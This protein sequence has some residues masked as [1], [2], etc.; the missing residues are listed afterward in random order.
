MRGRP[1]GRL[2]YP[3]GV[4]AGRGDSVDWAHVTD[5]H[6]LCGWY[7][8]RGQVRHRLLGRRP[9]RLARTG[10]EVG[11]AASVRERR[12]RESGDDQADRRWSVRLPSR[13]QA[14]AVAQ[15]LG[16]WHAGDS[17]DHRQ[18]VLSSLNEQVR[19]N[20]I[21]SITCFRTKIFEYVISVLLT[22]R[23]DLFDKA[24]YIRDRLTEI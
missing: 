14:G 19:D 5:P 2:S 6:V 4:V 3:V 9:A 21:R 15:A 13:Q 8:E 18:V 20:S 16:R 10:R 22:K 1:E 12:D 23:A 24:G 11:S 7:H 17:L